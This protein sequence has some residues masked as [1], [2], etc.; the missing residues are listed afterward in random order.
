VD[1]PR[2]RRIRPRRRTVN[3]AGRVRMKIEMGCNGAGS[4]INSFALVSYLP[5]PLAGFF[6]N[7]RSELVPACSAKAHVTVLPPRP[8]QCPPEDA[9]EELKDNLQDFQPFR[10]DLAE[11]EIFAVTQVIYVSVS[12]GTGELKRMHAALNSGR[13]QFTEPFR[14]CPHITLAQELD[15]ARVEAAAAL[16]GSRWREFSHSRSFT[17]GR[18]TFVQNTLENRW[19]DLAGCSL[20]ERVT[21]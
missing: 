1:A 20:S 3:A 10:V 16:A 5:E 2:N 14:Y 8:L 17:V 4:R 18:L 13:L 15:P 11:V 6:D 12:T 21:I 7:L 19:T 9:W